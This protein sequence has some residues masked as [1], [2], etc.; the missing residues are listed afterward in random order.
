M[1]SQDTKARFIEGLVKEIKAL[2]DTMKQDGLRQ[3]ARKHMFGAMSVEQ[4]VEDNKQ[5]LEK[6]QRLVD[7]NKNL[8]EKLDKT[9]DNGFADYSK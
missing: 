2:K 4:L 9:K 5:L 3:K 8:Q 6:C 1:D 7:E